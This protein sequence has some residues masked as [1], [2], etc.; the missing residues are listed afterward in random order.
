MKV[1]M[2]WLHTL[3]QL[4]E[5]INE[6]IDL[7]HRLDRCFL[8]GFAR[9]EQTHAETLDSLE[10]VFQGTP[11]H[12]SLQTSCAAL[13][14]SEFLERHFAGLAAARAALQG[15]LFDHLQHHA[16][17]VLGRSHP[18]IQDETLSSVAE[19]DAPIA[20]WLESTRHWL[21][22]IALAGFAKLAP[23]T[24]VPFLSTLEQMQE[25]PQLIRQSALLTGFLD[26]LLQTV[27]VTETQSIPL[28]RWMD[29]WMRGMVMSLQILSVPATESVSGNLTLLGCDLRSHPHLMSVV[30]YGIL[31][32]DSQRR[33]ARNTFSSYK[34]DAISSNEVWLLFQQAAPLF[35]ALA[36]NMTIHISDMPLTATSDL[37]WN[38]QAKPGR[39]HQPLEEARL[40][41]APETEDPVASCAVAPIDRHPAQLAEPVFLE[42][43]TVQREEERLFLDWGEHGRLPV[44]TERIHALSELTNEVITKSSQMFGLLRF[45]AGQWGIQ[46][47]GVICQTGKGKKAKTEIVLT[48]QK[49]AAVLKKPPKTST[50]AILQERASRLLRR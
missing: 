9:L 14:G 1:P 26:E 40:A 31:D 2:N 5:G 12:A 24:L 21:M 15:A 10:R 18:D 46:P 41:F 38:G 33:L 8:S 25:E 30:M 17:E 42:A 39:K 36:K 47:I 13:K 35:E 7:L 16:R 19:P 4:P 6:L 37:L 32:T 27:P 49:A 45:D 44:I 34:V 23:E 29:L 50:I 48:G 11:L 3:Q 28:T 20:T 43:Y 22:E